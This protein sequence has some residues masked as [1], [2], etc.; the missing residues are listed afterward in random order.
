MADGGLDALREE[1]ERLRRRVAELEARIAEADVDQV[2]MES[3]PH[4]GFFK[5]LEG[6]FMK[7]NAEFAKLFA[8]RPDDL[9]GKTDF[10]LVPHELA[11]KY[12]ADD[13]RVMRS[14][15]PVTLI[16]PNDT[17]QGRRFVE[18]SKAPA[19]DERGEV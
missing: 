5:D 12:R 4:K 16:E 10:D 17:G 3:L 9:I 7:V 18:V 15:T 2:L 14:R 6:R 1:N 8:V 11:I 19:I 13:Q